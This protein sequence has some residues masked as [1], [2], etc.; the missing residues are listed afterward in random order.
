MIAV[1]SMSL[2]KTSSVPSF[3]C[4]AAR[5][6]RADRSFA[7]SVNERLAS[8][9]SKTCPSSL[10]SSLIRP[11]PDRGCCRAPMAFRSFPSVFAPCA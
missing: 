1:A 2:K 5:R 9:I 11:A 7:F 8:L 6:N 10:P 3:P 4:R